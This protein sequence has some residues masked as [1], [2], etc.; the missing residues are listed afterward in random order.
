MAVGNKDLIAA[1]SQVKENTDSGVFNAIQ[2]AGVTALSGCAEN[3]GHM[4]GIYARRRQ[5]VLQTLGDVGIRFPPARGTFYLW[6]P[7]PKNMSSID[8]ATLL[9]EKARIV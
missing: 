8:F 9:F 2:F 4:L 6:A 5:L 7:T 1:I 3:V